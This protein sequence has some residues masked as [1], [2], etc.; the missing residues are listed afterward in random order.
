[1][2]RSVHDE[3]DAW[4]V[5]ALRQLQ[6]QRDMC[7]GWLYAGI[8]DD[9]IY[10]LTHEREQ[11]RES[12]HAAVLLKLKT[13]RATDRDSWRDALEAGITAARVPLVELS[14]KFASSIPAVERWLGGTSRPVL[15]LR[16]S[17]IQFLVDR[18]LAA[19]PIWEVAERLVADVPA[20]AWV[21]VPPAKAN[22][23]HECFQQGYAAGLREGLQI[24]ENSAWVSDESM[25]PCIVWD[26]VT[27]EI[28]ARV[29]AVLAAT[30]KTPDR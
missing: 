16:D 29:N 23:P 4:Y 17:V 15:P 8:L 19:P 1:M 24:A 9:K 7:V 3:L 25:T 28:E 22:H 20:E 2:K 30:T 12:P 6:A 14:E 21:S 18:L 26:D 5:E 13:V 11:A 10:R 27:R